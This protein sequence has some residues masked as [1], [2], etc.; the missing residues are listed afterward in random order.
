M[1]QISKVAKPRAHLSF[2]D[3]VERA[4]LRASNLVTRVDQILWFC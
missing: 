4:T 3:E 2:V 1:T